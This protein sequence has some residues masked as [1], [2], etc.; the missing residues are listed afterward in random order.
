MGM[1]NKENQLSSGKYSDKDTL[2]WQPINNS[3]RGT[4]HILPSRTAP[5]K[6]LMHSHHFTPH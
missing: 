5:S 1:G 4:S 6:E 2:A 3:A